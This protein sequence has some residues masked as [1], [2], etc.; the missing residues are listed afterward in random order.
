MNHAKP[1]P[2]IASSPISHDQIENP[3]DPTGDAVAIGSSIT[4]GVLPI[5][6]AA[7]ESGN[8]GGLLNKSLSGAAGRALR[9]VSGVAAAGDV[10]R[11]VVGAAAGG[12]VLAGGGTVAAGRSPGWVTVPLSE[13]LDNPPGPISFGLAGGAPG[14]ALLSCAASGPAAAS[15]VTASVLNTPFAIAVLRPNTRSFTPRLWP[16]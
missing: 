2:A 14:A 9:L 1:P 8:V 15:Q 3:P 6:G 13:K 7:L 16:D 11:T 4:G 10:P 12:A 5:T